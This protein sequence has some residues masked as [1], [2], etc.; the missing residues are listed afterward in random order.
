[1]MKLSLWLVAVL[2]MGSIGCASKRKVKEVDNTKTIKKDYEVRDASSNFRPAWIEDIQTWAEQEKQDEKWRWFAFETEPKV[3]REI[4]C[5]LAKANARAD[6][7]GEITT[8]IQK[9]LAESSEGQAAIDPNNPK[10]QALRNYV[11]NNLTERVQSLVHGA[12][13]TRT[14]WEKRQ[15]MQSKG[16]PKDYIGFT[17]AVQVRIDRKVLQDAINKAAQEIVSKAEDSEVKENV[18]KALEKID[19]DFLKARRGEV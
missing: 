15:F 18:K 19:E 9:T 17:C 6:V 14:Y 2:M 11:A 13:V 10:T 1:M 8:F 5:N 4:A 3:N 7:A 16:A 12:A